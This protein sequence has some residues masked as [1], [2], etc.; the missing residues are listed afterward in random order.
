MVFDCN[1]V[2]KEG[3]LWV[4]GVVVWEGG[5][6]SNVVWSCEKMGSVSKVVWSCGKS[7]WSFGKVMWSCGMVVWSYEEYRRWW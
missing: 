3:A 2:G 4:G 5:S 1:C 7:S 6:M